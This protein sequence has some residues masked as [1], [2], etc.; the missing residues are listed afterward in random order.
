MP[1]PTVKEIEA[2]V[3]PLQARLNGA[4]KTETVG[5]IT[6]ADGSEIVTVVDVTQLLA[7]VAV[8]V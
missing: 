5:V 8:S 3:L 2:G 1:P 6:I 4:S 7:S